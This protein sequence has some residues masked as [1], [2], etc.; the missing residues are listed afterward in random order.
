MQWIKYWNI[1]QK[2]W[3]LSTS[4][5]TWVNLLSY[6]QTKSDVS[7]FLPTRARLTQSCVYQRRTRT[8]LWNQWDLL[9]SKTDLTWW[10]TWR[11]YL[12]PPLSQLQLTVCDG[13]GW[14]ADK[15]MSVVHT[16]LS[17][18]YRLSAS[19]IFVSVSL[20]FSDTKNEPPNEHAALLT[21][22]GVI[23]ITL[24]D[25]QDLVCR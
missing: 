1:C 14:H 8:K 13:S 9:S 10:P 24:Y 25:T 19:N 16:D 2:R 15:R 23:I 17:S 11:E 22:A 20:L 21:P 6:I 12:Q 5:C 7:T 3:S 4:L 18:L